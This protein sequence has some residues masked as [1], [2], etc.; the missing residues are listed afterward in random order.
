[1]TVEHFGE[2]QTKLHG[3]H[4]EDGN[5]HQDCKKEEIW[6]TKINTYT[7][8]KG[9]S[10]ICF[11][12]IFNKMANCKRCLRNLSLLNYFNMTVLFKPRITAFTRSFKKGQAW[13]QFLKVYKINNIPELL[14]VG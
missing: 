7:F 12:N 14:K 9:V 8:A 5:S 2:N 6:I 3:H 4:P 10:Y 13:F 1:M 11:K